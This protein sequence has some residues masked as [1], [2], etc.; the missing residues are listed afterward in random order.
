MSIYHY[1][2]PSQAGVRLRFL[3]LDHA[4]NELPVMVH[5][6]P[7]AGKHGE[8]FAWGAGQIRVS[9]RKLDPEKSTEILPYL[10]HDEELLLA[11]GEVVPVDIEIPPMAMHFRKGEKLQLVIAGH[12]LFVPEFAF[13]ARPAF[14]DRGTTLIHT[15]GRYQSHL[16]LPLQP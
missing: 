4:G 13:L 16:L 14:R 6:S 2:S 5:G 11:G 3:K 12:P 9:Q 7:A 8:R 15:G 1:C 10:A